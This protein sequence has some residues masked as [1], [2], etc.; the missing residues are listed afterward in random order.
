MTPATRDDLAEVFLY[1]YREAGFAAAIEAVGNAAVMYST[2]KP[3]VSRKPLA[4]ELD[5]V[6]AQ[7]AAA[8]GTTVGL[9][10]NNRRYQSLADDR[11]I[12]CWLLRL[13]GMAWPKL[14]YPLIAL[15]LGMVNHTSALHGARR[16]DG[17]EMLLARAK[18]AAARARAERVAA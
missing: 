9:L 5:H 8:M 11:H 4:S 12:A 10:R 15:A 16:V 1:A 17:N 14:S 7:V 2:G 13:E 6:V 3:R 18:V